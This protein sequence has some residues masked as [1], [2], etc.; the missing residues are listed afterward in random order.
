M[1]VTVDRRGTRQGV[2]PNN[3]E[4]AEQ[5]QVKSSLLVII[6][7][8]EAK[9]KPVWVIVR[10]FRIDQFRDLLQRRPVIEFFKPGIKTLLLTLGL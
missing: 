6:T 3:N 2:D 4:I 9:G 5:F 8:S 1:R 7:T 10:R